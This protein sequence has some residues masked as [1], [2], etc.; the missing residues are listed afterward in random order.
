MKELIPV[1][2]IGWVTLV[3]ILFMDLPARRAAITALVAGWLFLPEASLEMKGLPDYSKSAAISVSLLVATLV[4]RTRNL[5]KF[6]LRW[7]DAPMGAWCLGPMLSS[8]ANGLGVWDGF[9][10][11]VNNLLLWGIPYLIGRIYITDREGLRE[12]ALGIF[13]GGLMYVPLCLW[14]IR[15]S[16]QLHYMLYDVRPDFF[17][18]LVRYGGFRPTVFMSTGLRLAFWMTVATV[19][20]F[21]LWRGTRLRQLFSC[22][23]WLLILVMVFTLVLCKTAFA[24]IVLPIAV[25]LPLALVRLRISWPF[26]ILILMAPTYV[27]LR[28]SGLWEAQSV[29]SIAASIDELRAESLQSRISHENSLSQKAL[30]RPILGWGRWGRSRVTDEWGRDVSRTD[31]M[32]IMA[33]GQ[34][35][36]LGV[37]SLL[38]FYVVPL[39]RFVRK[40]PGKEWA[41]SYVGPAAAIALV[42][43][44]N[45][46]FNIPNNSVNPILTAALGGL[47]TFVDLRRPA[48]KRAVPEP[49]EHATQPSANPLSP[50]RSR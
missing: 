42:G 30:Q 39:L 49:P 8:I 34:Q 7:H 23:L 14:E 46:I 28:T 44:V 9:S 33:F 11:V 31:G 27:A 48:P 16:P 22:P 15:M 36:F 40:Y 45:L 20:G 29:V 10:A 26:V 50:Q 32:W 13:I 19:A 12:F 35:G 21:W 18:K 4:F 1:A 43:L 3:L 41:N 24:Y 17:R 2:L 6:R 25:L 38:A 47:S 37:V 5:R